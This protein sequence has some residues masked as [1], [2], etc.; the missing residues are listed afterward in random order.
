[1]IE[2][3]KDLKQLFKLC[4][5]Q[6]V[7]KFKMGDIEIDFGVMPQGSSNQTSDA[8]DE[9]DLQGEDLL[10]YS[11]PQGQAELDKKVGVR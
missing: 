2:S 5:A 10:F 7:D 6:G 11:T 1:M 4:R 9:D 8:V 3:I